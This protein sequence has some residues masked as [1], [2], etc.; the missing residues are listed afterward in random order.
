MTGLSLNVYDSGGRLRTED[1]VDNY[2]CCY[3]DASKPNTYTIAIYGYSS[4]ARPISGTFGH[5]TT[6]DGSPPEWYGDEDYAE[7]YSG[8]GDTPGMTLGYGGDPGQKVQIQIIYRLGMITP[9]LSRIAPSI[10][11]RGIATMTNEQFGSTGVQSNAVLPPPLPNLPP[12]LDPVPTDLVVN[13]LEGPQ[14]YGSSSPGPGDPVTFRVNA[15]NQGELDTGSATVIKLYYVPNAPLTNPTPTD[16]TGPGSAPGVVEV[17]AG[18]VPSLLQQGQ[19]SP[20]VDISFSFPDGGTYYM[21]A[22]VDA[23]NQIDEAGSPPNQ[24]LG[25]ESNNVSAPLMVMVSS[26]ADLV[27]TK[28]VDDPAPA[29]NG[30]VKFTITLTNLGGASATNVVLDDTVPSPLQLQTSGGNA[31]NASMGTYS[32]TDF[33][34]RI[35]SIAMGQTATLV[36]TARVP[37]GTAVGTTVT[38]EVTGLAM[39]PSKTDPDRTNDT[40]CT[41]GC[42]S[43]TIVVGAINLTLVKTVSN[44]NPVEDADTPKCPASGPTKCFTY[45]LTARNVSPV[46]PATNVQI[47]DTLPAG[48]TYVSSNPATGCTASGQTVTCSQGTLAPSATS[49]RTLTVYAN[50][51]SG[52]QTLEN[53]ATVTATEVDPD[54]SNNTS[55][56]SVLVQSIDIE[57]VKTITP[58]YSAT[59]N[60]F[61][62]RVIV[63]NLGPNTANNVRIEDVIPTGSLNAGFTVTAPAGT[64]WSAPN[65]TINTLAVN[66]SVTLTIVA[67]GRSST[68]NTTINNTATFISA[69]KTDVNS[70]NNTATAGARITNA[71]A[72]DIQLEKSVSPTIAGPNTQIVYSF[73]VTNNGPL[74]ATGVVVTDAALAAATT[75]S[76]ATSFFNYVTPIPAAWNQSSGTWNAVTLAAGASQTFTLTL[77]LNGN[78]ST[79][80]Y[81]NTA[82]A[83][84]PITDNDPTNNS[85][86][87]T[88]NVNWPKLVFYNAGGAGCNGVTWGNTDGDEPTPVSPHNWL[89]TVPYTAGLSGV[90][91]S[92][93]TLKPPAVGYNFIDRS[94]D[95]LPPDGQNLMACA[96]GGRNFY[97]QFDGLAPGLYEI[98]LVFADPGT[99][100]AKR[101]FT[102]DAMAFK[103]KTGRIVRNLDV[104]FAV[105]DYSVPASP[106]DVHYYVRTYK[107]RVVST[108]RPYLKIHFIAGGGGTYKIREAIINGIGITY[109]SP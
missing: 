106:T 46:T 60:N 12:L 104:A 59:N 6:P 24:D 76:S 11:M 98:T 89:P 107:Y 99:L 4:A 26:E 77:K 7:V 2:Q 96:V 108:V 67:Q 40:S 27:L 55:R 23:T 73:K 57:V 54:M 18:T 100:I 52:G 33:K 101:R 65:W 80:I 103:R 102:V 68:N 61:T 78:S 83:S 85:S 47:V 37:A 95:T 86:T 64:T 49:V 21:Y 16:L 42:K 88:L 45:T 71:N 75:P 36:L 72:A 15:L 51:G 94:G 39:D 58:L 50:M 35:P 43:A 62:W 9:I 109:D 82:S 8:E 3:Y 19:V 5:M 84:A 34:W 41:N 97:Y 31:P 74:T 91:G 28:R 13:L 32:T 1:D 70:A 14:G 44:A 63:R 92:N 69:D 79:P 38:N 10:E 53:T 56:V 81:S 48:I 87:A 93:F 20:S 25:R 105:K 17:G 66:A 22:V 90:Y 30:L 29:P